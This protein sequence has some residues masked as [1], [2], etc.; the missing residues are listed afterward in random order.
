M[1]A[2]SRPILRS[3]EMAAPVGRQMICGEWVY[4]VSTDYSAEVPHGPKQVPNVPI[5]WIIYH[6]D[7]PVQQNHPP[8]KTR[9][10]SPLGSPTAP[11]CCGNTPQPQLS[12]RDYSAAIRRMPLPH[13]HN[14]P[15]HHSYM[16]WH[17]P[18]KWSATSGLAYMK[19][20]PTE[21]AAGLALLGEP[22]FRGSLA[23]LACAFPLPNGSLN[24]LHME[25]NFLSD[26]VSSTV[27]LVLQM[28]INREWEVDSPC[29]FHLLVLLNMPI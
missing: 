11:K 22:F 12:L 26:L 7:N 24:Y 18:L 2:E 29:Y 4:S 27:Y 13:E 17:Q 6:T 20:I 16:R 19:Q 14:A 21:T 8:G 25:T 9:P 28:A 10:T 23:L 3:T 15:T 1:R 5:R